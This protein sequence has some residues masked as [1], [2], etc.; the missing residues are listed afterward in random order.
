[1]IWINETDLYIF[2][3]QIQKI[4]ISSNF[5][6]TYNGVFEIFFFMMM[7]ILKVSCNNEMKIIAQSYSNTSS[8]ETKISSFTVA[9]I[10]QKCFNINKINLGLPPMIIQSI[11]N[12]VQQ[13]CGRIYIAHVPPCG[14][15]SEGSVIRGLWR[16]R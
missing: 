3:W 8:H 4:N 14:L 16:W 1:M 11:V 5:C 13:T 9:L 15:T 12:K 7:L 10:G 2:T 6:F